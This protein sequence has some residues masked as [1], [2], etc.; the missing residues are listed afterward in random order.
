MSKP[1]LKESAERIKNIRT[2]L[3]L[4]QADFA[5]LIGVSHYN[6]IGNWETRG[7]NLEENHMVA[8]HKIGINPLYPIG[9]GN[10]AVN[11]NEP[12]ETICDRARQKLGD[13]Q[14]QKIEGSE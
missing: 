13:L 2:C 6:T 9:I 14:S 11:S 5:K 4:S 12:W 3:G 10:M 7:P 1:V 8:L